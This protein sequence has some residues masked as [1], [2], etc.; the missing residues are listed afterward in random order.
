MTCKA[1][2]ITHAEMGAVTS[3]ADGSVTFR[4]L[5]PEL[6][7]SQAGALMGWHGKACRVIITPHDEAPEETVSIETERNA[8]TPSQRLR[9]VLYVLWQE[10]NLSEPF[11]DFYSKKIEGLIEAVKSKLPPQ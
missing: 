9:S 10:R 11:N 6:L 7:P 5:T 3:K 2:D 4:V 8:K 1:I